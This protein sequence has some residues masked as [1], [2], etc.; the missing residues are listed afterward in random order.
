MAAGSQ[1]QRLRSIA[2]SPINPT[3]ANDW[4][5]AIPLL[6]PLIVSHRVETVAKADHLN[7]KEIKIDASNTIFKAWMRPGGPFCYDPAP[8]LFSFLPV[9]FITT[10]LHYQLGME[11]GSR[12]VTL[13]NPKPSLYEEFKLIGVKFI[14]QFHPVMKKKR[15]CQHKSVSHVVVPNGGLKVALPAPGRC[16]RGCLSSTFDPSHPFFFNF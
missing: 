8:A 9:I 12:L 11:E 5:V 2:P 7:K 3:P 13:L 10:S 4:K 16:T 6:S 1:A 14:R 15:R